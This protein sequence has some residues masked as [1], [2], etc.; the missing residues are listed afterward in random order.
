M[1]SGTLQTYPLSGILDMTPQETYLI[2]INHD[3][4]AFIIS[5]NTPHGR[6]PLP[7][8]VDIGADLELEHGES[9]G[10]CFSENLLHLLA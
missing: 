4:V 7:I 5:Q 6:Q 9:L 10:N 2:C 3:C 1:A 8:S